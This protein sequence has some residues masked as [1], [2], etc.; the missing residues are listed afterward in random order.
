MVERRAAFQFLGIELAAAA[1]IAFALFRKHRSTVD[2]LCVDI[3][4]VHAF[5]G[6]EE[7]RVAGLVRIRR[8]FPTALPLQAFDVIL[9][10]VVVRQ[11][12]H[13]QLRH[14]P[15]VWLLFPDRLRL[16]DN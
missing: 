3:N 6:L 2:L 14:L 7:L 12:L 10:V 8:L 9:A 1:Q 11:R 16:F 13:D 5:L 4:A 15:L